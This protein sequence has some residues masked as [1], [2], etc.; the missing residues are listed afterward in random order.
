MLAVEASRLLETMC[1]T[2]Q[3]QNILNTCIRVVEKQWKLYYEIQCQE[4]C[5]CYYE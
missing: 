2:A 1:L 3:A 5:K 4:V